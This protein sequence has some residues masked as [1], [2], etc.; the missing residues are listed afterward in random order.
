MPGAEPQLDP[1]VAEQVGCG[2]RSRQQRRVP[3]S[4]VEHIGPQPHPRA[5][6]GGCRQRREGIRRAQVIGSG[7]HVAAQ[8][9]CASDH[10]VQGGQ[11]DRAAQRDSERQVGHRTTIAQPTGCATQ[12]QAEHRGPW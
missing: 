6:R 7:D 9:V 5:D 4:H 3:E 2:H 11:R 8:L 12:D 10:V 1:A